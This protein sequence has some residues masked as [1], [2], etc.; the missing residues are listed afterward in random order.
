MDLE[1]ISPVCFKLPQ[2]P[3]PSWLDIMKKYKWERAIMVDGNNQTRGYLTYDQEMAIFSN[4]ADELLELWKPSNITTMVRKKVQ[5][6]IS[7][8]VKVYK[9]LEK[10]Y[11]K[12]AEKNE[13]WKI[14]IHKEPGKSL[15]KFKKLF[16]I[17]QCQRFKNC[18]D[19]EMIISRKCS[20]DFSA[21]IATLKHD[22]NG[23]TDLEYYTDQKFQRVM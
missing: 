13:N 21:K 16:D 22:E 14:D 4:I 10:D 8:L 7:R 1:Q 12:K 19:P 3:L 5:D 9:F 15:E 17:A 2:N 18:T 20:C 11:A 6:K 23:F